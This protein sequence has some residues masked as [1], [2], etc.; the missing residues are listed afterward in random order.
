MVRVLGGRYQLVEALATGGMGTVWVAQDAVL[1]R[2]VA[3][4]ILRTDLAADPNFRE[5]FRREAVAAGA[6]S[7]PGIVAVFD[8]GEDHGVVYLVM[9]FIDG[10]SLRQQLDQRGPPTWPVAAR[11]THDIALALAA[12]H[13]HGVVHRDIKPANI[14]LASGALPK[15]ADFG[16][17]KTAGVSADL[18]HSGMVVGSARYLAPEQVHGEPADARTDIYAIGLLLY[19]LLT[20]RLPFHGETETQIAL[21]R[22]TTAPAALPATVPT[23]LARVVE[24]C[25]AVAPSSRYQTAN[26]LAE[27]LHSA[28]QP[29]SP[30]RAVPARPSTRIL[31]AP[32]APPRPRRRGRP[33]HPLYFALLLPALFAVGVVTGYLATQAFVT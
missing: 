27:D 30:P 31:N 9:E 14:L 29:P 13:A 23:S 17:A 25:L 3:V 24:Q 8:A 2:R 5:R 28:L 20:G 19:E 7:H 15:V 10:P 1:S 26:L 6:L 32:A 16:I 33:R 22:L 12:A 18:T 11:I 21:A 4:K